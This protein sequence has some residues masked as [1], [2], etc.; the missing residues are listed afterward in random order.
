MLKIYFLNTRFNRTLLALG[1]LL[2]A[3]CSGGDS[4]IEGTSFQSGCDG[5]C[6]QD[7]L[8]ESEVKSIIIQAQAASNAYGV[9]GTFAVVDR[10][11][12]VLAVYEMDGSNATTLID[13]QIGAVGGLEGAR[14]PSSLVAISKA[15]TAAYLS[16]QGNAFSTRTAS[17]IVQEHFDPGDANQPAGPLF[18]A[19]FSQLLCSDLTVKNTSKNGPRGLPLGLSADPG[20]FPLYKNGVVVGGVGVEIDGLY[21][22]DK[23]IR[24]FDNAE[25]IEN[26]DEFIALAS[27]VG[28][29]APDN[30]KGDSIF[31][32]GKSFRYSD[33]TYSDLNVVEIASASFDAGKYIAVPPF[34]AGQP[35]SGTTFGSLESGFANSTRMGLPT[36][37]LVEGSN[38]RFPSVNGSS[39]GGSELSKVEVDALLDSA[40]LTASKTRSAI[41][42]PKDTPARVS[43]WIVDT[44]G[45]QL[46]FVRSQDAPVF[47]TDVALQKAR[48]VVFFS[49]SDSQSK[50]NA[51]QELE[52]SNG[53]QI[54]DYY[55]NLSSKFGNSEISGNYAFSNRSIGNLTR[56]YFPDGIENTLN[57]PFSLPFPG[58]GVSST[59]RSWSPFNTGLQLDFILRNVLAPLSGVIP[60]TCVDSKV[61]GSRLANGV[62]IFPGA[63]P[64]YKNGTLVGG[65]GVSG[66]GVDQDDF[67]S[68]YSVSREALDSAGHLTVGDPV[69]GFNAPKEI[70]SD[71]LVSQ[72]ERLRLRYINC[73]ESAFI[74]SSIQKVCDAL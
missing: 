72:A 65:I 35:L 60:K 51:I 44:T 40:I 23:N 57:G 69:L 66:D 1:L 61:V 33:V 17:Q 48:T 46:G 39:I 27:T 43:I 26:L 14:V 45:R 7:H 53:V 58:K 29:E 56:P 15:G 71:N 2:L 55:S 64:L 4:N 18:G 12:N 54:E 47:G 34:F 32:I 52:R 68:F 3:S 8:D 16:S 19:Q 20:G 30:R 73:P 70:R 63:V 42:N 28:F 67:I 9:A 38:V 74:G 59:G 11:G 21:T 25:V 6:A 24:D 37:V 62:Q 49:S 10:V 31:L 13:G 5:T 41:R 50:V 36:A 22:F